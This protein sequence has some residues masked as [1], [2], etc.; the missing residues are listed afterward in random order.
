[1][2]LM[3]DDDFI[4]DNTKMFELLFGCFS[5]LLFIVQKR[6]CFCVKKKEKKKKE[7]KEGIVEE[8]AECMDGRRS[9]IYDFVE[10]LIEDCLFF[11]ACM[12]VT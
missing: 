11:G 2:N 1:L 4:I 9:P 3:N 8:E 12:W 5:L 6:I 7:K 10:K